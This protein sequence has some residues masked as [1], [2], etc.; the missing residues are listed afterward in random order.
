MEHTLSVNYNRNAQWN[1]H[2]Q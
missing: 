2:C 1:I